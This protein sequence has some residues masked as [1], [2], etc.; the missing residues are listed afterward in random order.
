M[1]IYLGTKLDDAN[2]LYA[3]GVRINGEHTN[4]WEVKQLCKKAGIKLTDDADIIYEADF[5]FCEFSIYDN[6]YDY[7][8][9]N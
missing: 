7:L 1:K 9:T 5:D 3:D 6:G 2:L 4:D 8:I